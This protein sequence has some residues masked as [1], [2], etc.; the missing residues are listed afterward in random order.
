VKQAIKLDN[1][2]RDVL[3]KAVI[4]GNLLRLTGQLDRRL[5]E[6]TNKALEAL[7][8]KWN[9][10]KKAHVFDGDP[11]A[12]IAAAAEDGKV[13]HP[14]EHDFFPTP[15]DTAELACNRLGLG[16]QWLRTLEPSAGHGDLIAPLIDW[17]GL[18]PSD[19]LTLV[20]M[21]ARRIVRL[22]GGRLE[23]YI[24][25]ADFLGM[26]PEQQPLFDRILMNPPFHNGADAVHIG[27]ALDFLAPGGRLVSIASASIDYKTTKTTKA[28]R[29]RLAAWGA[30]IEG[31]PDG[32]FKDAGTSVATVLITV[33]RPRAAR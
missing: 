30:T 14:N 8:G 11:R 13:A 22:A 31:L 32:S 12:A 25:A 21:D 5:Y 16:H 23:P 6:R 15:R 18:P 3:T 26:R 17:L 7:G 19:F 20:E 29:E 1:D 10:G 24:L 28:V 9:R 27:H 33:N 2:V 4:E